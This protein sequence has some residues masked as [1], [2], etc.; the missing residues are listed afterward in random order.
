MEIVSL[1]HSRLSDAHVLEGYGLPTIDLLGQIT[2]RMLSASL[3]ATPHDA[4][5][6]AGTFAYLAGV[7]AKRD[8]LVPHGWVP[9]RINNLE[10]TAHPDRKVALM[11]ASGDKLT[12]NV[13]D[14]HHPRTRNHKGSQTT[15]RVNFNSRQLTFLG[16]GWDAPSNKK[17]ISNTWILLSHIDRV[18]KEM[19]FEISLPIG[20]DDSGHVDRWEKRLIIPSIPFGDKPIPVKP[21]FAPDAEIIIRRR[22]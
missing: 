10:L 22:N 11:V 9:E 7:R 17:A 3:Q 4:L 14:E 2:E 1:S 5:N 13:D 8:I 20:M 12:G 16:D 19:R 18:A 15:N 6:A 21:D